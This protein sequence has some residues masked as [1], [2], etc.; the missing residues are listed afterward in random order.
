MVPLKIKNG[1]LREKLLKVTQFVQK[2]EENILGQQWQ[3]KP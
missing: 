2:Q 3:K 1:G